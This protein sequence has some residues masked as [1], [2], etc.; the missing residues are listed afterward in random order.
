MCLESQWDIL[1]RVRRLEKDTGIE[2]VYS[3]QLDGR[4]KTK[5]HSKSQ[6]TQ[7]GKRAGRSSFCLKES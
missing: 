5:L 6:Y 3:S 7:L 4:R 2:K 1:L